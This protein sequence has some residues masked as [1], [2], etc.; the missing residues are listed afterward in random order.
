MGDIVVGYENDRGSLRTCSGNITCVLSALLF[1][2]KCVV[3][4]VQSSGDQKLFSVHVHKDIIWIQVRLGIPTTH[5][6]LNVGI[7]SQYDHIMAL[8]ANGKNELDLCHKIIDEGMNNMAIG[9]SYGSS[10]RVYCVDKLAMTGSEGDS[11]KDILMIVFFQI[12]GTVVMLKW[13]NMEIMKNDV[14]I[15][16]DRITFGYPAS[17]TFDIGSSHFERPVPGTM[18]FIEEDEFS[19]CEGEQ[20]IVELMITASNDIQ[21]G[22]IAGR[23]QQSGD[24]ITCE[25]D[26]YSMDQC[27]DLGVDESKEDALVCVAGIL[28][29][30]MR[31]IMKVL[32]NGAMHEMIYTL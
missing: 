24:L 23:C 9:N 3:A 27:D 7:I 4:Q 10:A 30:Y 16:D 18:E 14:N 12:F 29:Q 26:N 31:L 21:R 22:I 17:G 1:R 19:L 2:H 6:D 25:I 13:K 28:L 5:N 20:D 11:D 32:L 15:S 8:H